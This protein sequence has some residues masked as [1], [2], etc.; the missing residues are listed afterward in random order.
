[1]T[2]L[3]LGASSDMGCEFIKTV[4]GDYDLILA[5]YRSTKAGL[6][7]LQKEYG[8]KIRLMQA[9]LSVKED[10]DAFID[11]ITS[12]N[13]HP[14]HVVHF[15]AQRIQIQ[16]FEKTPWESFATGFD[17]SVKS[18]VLIMQKI[19]PKMAKAKYGRVVVMLS[20]AVNGVPP[21]YSADYVMTKYA[22]LGLV[23]SLGLEYAGKGIC[24][25]GVSPAFVETKFVDDMAD[26]IKEEQKASSPIGRNLTPA[27]VVPVIKWLLSDEAAYVNGANIPITCGR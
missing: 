5:H 25:N 26:F 3:V 19:F 21:K 7:T 4:A 17:I 23:K 15:P 16:K 8:K 22:L 12:L 11:E 10:V 14:C 20:D 9:D 6:E 2:L 24:V 18:F 13:E 27:D 1:M